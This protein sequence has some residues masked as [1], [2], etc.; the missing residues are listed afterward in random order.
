M[1]TP[2]GETPGE[3]YLL[4]LQWR[5]RGE[6]FIVMFA[7]FVQLTTHE[8]S[9]HI[10][11]GTVTLVGHNP[12]ATHKDVTGHGPHVLKGINLSNMFVEVVKFVN[13]SVIDEIVLEHFSS[14]LVNVPWLPAVI[15]DIQVIAIGFLAP[16]L[17][18]DIL[19]LNDFGKLHG[20]LA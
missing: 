8:A 16:R 5:C 17:I 13:P 1:P 20:M 12:A 9:S 15:V 2:F 14:T 19:A 3:E 18:C 7:T 4:C 10:G 6:E 11:F